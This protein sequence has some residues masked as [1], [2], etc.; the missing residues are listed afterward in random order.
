MP[1]QKSKKPAKSAAK[2]VAK[3][4]AKPEFDAHRYELAVATER[5]STKI[6]RSYQEVLSWARELVSFS[7]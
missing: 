6:E 3:A 2:P 1:A 7:V 4:S 5:T